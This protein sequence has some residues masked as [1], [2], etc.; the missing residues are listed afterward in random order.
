MFR[1]T[2]MGGY[3]V[4]RTLQSWQTRGFPVAVLVF[5]EVVARIAL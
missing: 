5:I 3:L 1:S 4:S 2:E